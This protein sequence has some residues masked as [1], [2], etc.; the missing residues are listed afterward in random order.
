[1]RTNTHTHTYTHMHTHTLSL[2]FPLRLLYSSPR[3][4]CTSTHPQG[5]A[6]TRRVY[7]HQHLWLTHDH[8]CALPRSRVLCPSP[9]QLFSP[10]YC[11]RLKPVSHCCFTP[12]HAGLVPA[13]RLPYFWCTHTRKSEPLFSFIHRRE[14]TRQGT[15]EW[16]RKR[17]EGAG[18]KKKRTNRKR[19]GE[20]RAASRQPRHVMVVV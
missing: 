2:S 4:C 20:T 7:P 3:C 5:P 19:A 9:N 17:R 11:L 15:R 13:A 14:E 18:K 6:A 16:R 8:R 10:S 1:M 12:S